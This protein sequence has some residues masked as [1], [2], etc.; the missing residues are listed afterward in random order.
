MFNAFHRRVSCESFL[1]VST[2][3]QALLQTKL[4]MLCV[5]HKQKIILVL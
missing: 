5:I 2:C 1:V 3:R 4:L